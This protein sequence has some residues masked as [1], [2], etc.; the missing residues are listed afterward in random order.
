M[1]KDIEDIVYS[2]NV[3]EFVTVSAE[4]VAFI[5]SHEKFESKA[6]IEKLH[7]ILA[8]LYLK[9]SLIPNFEAAIDEPSEKFL[10]EEEW[11]SLK[12]SISEKLSNGD[13]FIRVNETDTQIEDEGTSVAISECITDIYQDISDFLQNYRLATV[14]I[15]NVSLWECVDNFKYYWG[16]RLI[17]V[18]TT[19]HNLLYGDND[20]DN[21]DKI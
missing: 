10:L 18:L 14:E 16:Q 12:N 15:M 2:K 6:F 4:F 13:I 17:S 11:I 21:D 7:K 3:L 1:T 9:A 5:E 20:L 8:L 19:F